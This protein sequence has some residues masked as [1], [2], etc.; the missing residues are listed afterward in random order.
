MRVNFEGIIGVVNLFKWVG[1]GAF[2][3]GYVIIR[4]KIG[5][6]DICSQRKRNCYSAKGR[7]VKTTK[8]K[9]ITKPAAQLPIY[10]SELDTL[11]QTPIDVS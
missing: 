8:F 9:T 11:F 7:L 1:L 6:S 3:R 2:W 5:A 10:D 4:H